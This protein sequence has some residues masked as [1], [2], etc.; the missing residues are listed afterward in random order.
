MSLQRPSEPGGEIIAHQELDRQTRTEATLGSAAKVPGK[1]KKRR[2]EQ[3]PVISADTDRAT[4]LTSPPPS[5]KIV[6]VNLEHKALVAKVLG[7]SR[8]QVAWTSFTKMMA[9]MGFF[10]AREKWFAIRIRRNN[11]GQEQKH[12][13]PSA[14]SVFLL[15]SERKPGRKV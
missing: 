13:L 6:K 3:P 2:A 8:K 11:L 7:S 15:E 5:P 12:D 14:S 10:D 4:I 9:E 1:Q